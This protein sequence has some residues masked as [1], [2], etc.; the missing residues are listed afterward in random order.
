MPK[1]TGGSTAKPE[2]TSVM[3]CPACGADGTPVTGP[4]P[5]GGVSGRSSGGTS[6]TE[7]VR[8]WVTSAAPGALA[9]RTTATVPA[10]SRVVPEIVAVPPTAVK[11]RPAGSG[12]ARARDVTA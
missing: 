12:P 10:A 7:R 6:T 8:V 9:V 2:A 5:A 4:S 3:L 1:V 11:V